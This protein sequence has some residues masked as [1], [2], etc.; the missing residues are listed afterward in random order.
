MGGTRGG[1]FPP[2]NIFLLKD[3]FWL[4]TLRGENKRIWVTVGGKGCMYMFEPIFP[5]FLTLLLDL[6]P[7]THGQFPDPPPPPTRPLNVISQV[8]PID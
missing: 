6:T 4:L 7:S 5:L 1:K 8:T 2:T 3:I